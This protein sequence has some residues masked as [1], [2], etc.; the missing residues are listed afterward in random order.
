MDIYFSVPPTL[1]Q[2]EPIMEELKLNNYSISCRIFGGIGWSEAWSV[3][4]GV[5]VGGLLHYLS[6]EMQL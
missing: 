1:L 2:C 6:L 4:K 5:Y 3:D